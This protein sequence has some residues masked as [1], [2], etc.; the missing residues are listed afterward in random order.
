MICKVKSA[1]EKY[2]MHPEG[3]RVVVALSGGADSMAM[4]H[5]L[6]CLGARVCACHFE[7]GIRGESSVSD[8]EFVKAYCEKNGIGLFVGRGD[9]PR[10]AKEQG[11]SLEASTSVRRSRRSA[12]GTP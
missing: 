1:L 3:K 4:L 11:M 10:F 6:K 7:H 12:H 9:V 5:A 2:S 8:M